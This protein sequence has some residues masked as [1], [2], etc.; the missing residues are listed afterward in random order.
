MTNPSTDDRQT[1]ERIA[2]WN[3]LYE[4]VRS[5]DRATIDIGIFVLKVVMTINAVALV[6]II[7]AKVQ[8]NG[9]PGGLQFFL[10]LLAAAAAAVFAYFWQRRITEGLWHDFRT[11]FPALGE[12][13]PFPNAWK[14]V[15]VFEWLVIP[16]VITSY[17]LFSWGGYLVY[18]ASG[19]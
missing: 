11:N 1:Q 8:L 14:H 10:G 19:V 3:G 13:P 15:T 9:I 16:L 6:A 4:Q 17:V 5:S 2:L 12:P 7:A 18:Y